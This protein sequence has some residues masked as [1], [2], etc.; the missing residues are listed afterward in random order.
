MFWRRRKKIGLSNRFGEK[1]SQ[2]FLFVQKIRNFEPKIRF[3]RF[4][5][6]EFSVMKYALMP[7][8]LKA[9]EL[10]SSK[11]FSRGVQTSSPPAAQLR[12]NLGERKP[13]V[14]DR[15]TIEQ[16][17]KIR[18]FSI[19][20]GTQQNKRNAHTAQE[21]Y[22]N[23][24]AMFRHINEIGDRKSSAFSKLLLSQPAKLK[25]KNVKTL[26]NDS[27]KKAKDKPILR[28]K[29]GAEDPVKMRQTYYAFPDIGGSADKE[30]KGT[31]KT[32]NRSQ[33]VRSTDSRFSPTS[34]NPM[35]STKLT[36]KQNFLAP[37]GPGRER[38]KR[39]PDVFQIDSK[40]S[41]APELRSPEIFNKIPIFSSKS[42]E[43]RADFKTQ[44]AEIILESNSMT[45][46]RFEELYRV[47]LEKSPEARSAAVENA[48]E[49]VKD[50]LSE[51]FERLLYEADNFELDDDEDEKE[52][53]KMY[54]PYKPYKKSD[55][56]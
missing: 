49:E 36:Y 33:F 31:S 46:S 45:P 32:K 37:E 5:K 18:G 23:L 54:N 28:L 8:D 19:P 29:H 9:L 39:W 11:T 27:D 20:S 15:L 12:E 34:T 3:F 24:K 16:W 17:N 1:R 25:T 51:R 14:Y 55:C 4:S 10:K 50:I 52:N 35:S 7:I 47:V 42:E 13:V 40:T 43:E 21:H 26:Q 30:L 6:D 38:V 48:F 44:L 56:M 2:N 41:R 53:A 22:F